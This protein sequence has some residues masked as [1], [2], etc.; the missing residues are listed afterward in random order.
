MSEQ[1]GVSHEAGPPMEKRT[2]GKIATD[3]MQRDVHGDITAGERM[4]EML[5][6]YESGVFDAI[7]NGKNSFSGDFYIVA[8]TKREQL[9]Q[10][11]LRNYFIPRQSCPTPD[12]DQVV[13]RYSRKDERLDMLWTLPSIAAIQ[14]LLVHKHELD[15]SFFQLLQFVLDFLDGKLEKMAQIL[16]NEH[17]GTN[18]PISLKKEMVNDGRI[19][20]GGISGRG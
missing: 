15:P 14:N 11:I 7:S 4:Q 5:G 2:A 6:E 9:M 16:N 19:Q 18:N 13:Y 20:T 3:L 17:I 8:L 1:K 10:N 12:F